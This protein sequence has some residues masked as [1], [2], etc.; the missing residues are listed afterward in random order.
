MMPKMRALSCF[1][2]L[3]SATLGVAACTERSQPA[4]RAA[5]N[6]IRVSG[7][8]VEAL[9]G[10]PYTYLRIKT[11]TGEVWAAVPVTSVERNSPIAVVNGV[12]LRDFDTGVSGRRF[13]VVF[14][15]LE[16]GR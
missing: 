14:G 5:S 1:L 4:P 3:A 12:L 9:D 13:D 6:T 16:R 7:M 2:V 15:T 10:P 11:E 8:L